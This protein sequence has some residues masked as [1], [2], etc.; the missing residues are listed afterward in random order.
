MYKLK[1]ALITA[2]IFLYMICWNCF[3]PW[4]PSVKSRMCVLCYREL[5][6]RKGEYLYLLRQ[7]DKN[8]FLGERHGLIGIFPVS[9][10]EVCAHCRYYT[11]ITSFC[12]F[13]CIPSQTPGVMFRL[14]VLNGLAVLSSFISLFLASC[15][16]SSWLPYVFECTV[17]TAYHDD[18]ECTIVT[19]GLC[20]HSVGH[21]MRVYVQDDS[22]KLVDAFESHF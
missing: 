5:S 17:I 7:V 3:K 4:M 14:Q 8:W 20:V 22:E 11:L 9:Y 19:V 16:S 2:Y 15:C 10:V 18:W 21:F 12:T 6:F 1:Y 13:F